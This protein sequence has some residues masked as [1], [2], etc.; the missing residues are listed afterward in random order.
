VLRPSFDTCLEVKAV[1]HFFVRCV[2]LSTQQGLIW[3]VSGLKQ[4]KPGLPKR[5]LPVRRRTPLSYY[6][7][8]LCVCL[9]T[10]SV[11]FLAR[12]MAVRFTFAAIRWR[13]SPRL[14]LSFLL[15]HTSIPNQSSQSNTYLDLTSTLPKYSLRSFA[16]SPIHQNY[17]HGAFRQEIIQA[18]HHHRRT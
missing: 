16:P 17:I 11:L 5:A 1:T 18:S 9:R 2:L 7:Q 13:L 12:A 15:Y 6:V 14:S 8:F 10:Q 4:W 3:F